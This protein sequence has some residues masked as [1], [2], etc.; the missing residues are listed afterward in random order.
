M[1]IL[2]D[3]DLVSRASLVAL[4]RAAEMGQIVGRN[5][6]SC[7]IGILA[8]A[9]GMSYRQFKLTAGLPLDWRENPIELFV[10]DICSGH[11]P[12]KSAECAHLVMW[13]DEAMRRRTGA[14]VS[15]THA[16]ERTEFHEIGRDSRGNTVGYEIP[17]AVH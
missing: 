8:E 7:F 10:H 5:K 13:C 4:T 6:D 2:T 16:S 3:E 11:T 1:A 14:S 17:I 15:F 12:E 9:R